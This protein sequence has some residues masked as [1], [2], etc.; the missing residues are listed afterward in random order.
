MLFFA[1]PFF[2]WLLLLVPILPLFFAV[3]LRFRCRRIAK[4]G[5]PA[6]VERLMPHY[7]R[8]KA[9]VRLILFDLERE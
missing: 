5:E 4:F 2:L 3:A 1:K 6:L 9:W 7:S 8:S